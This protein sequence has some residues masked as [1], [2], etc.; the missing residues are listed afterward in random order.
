M[1]GFTPTD[2]QKMLI[3]TAVR[4]AK[5]DLRAAGHDADVGKSLPERLVSA[6][7]CVSE[8]PA[9]SG[10]CRTAVSLLAAGWSNTGS[11]DHFIQGRAQSRPAADMFDLG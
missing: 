1:Y 11:H 8:K 7:I 6:S 3:D 9:G 2:E 4:Y 5:T 10:V